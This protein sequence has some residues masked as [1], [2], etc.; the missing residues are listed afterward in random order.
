MTAA[1]AVIELSDVELKKHR[2]LWGD[3]WIQF[4]KHRLAM[5]GVGILGLLI[6]AVVAGPLIYPVDAAFIDVTAANSPPTLQHLFG[7]DNLGRD[8]DLS[9]ESCTR[10]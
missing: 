3:V 4:R 8:T 1:P 7:T 5:V 9:P 10:E 2:S 6:F